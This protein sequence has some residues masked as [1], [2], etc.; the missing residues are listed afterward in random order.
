MRMTVG[1]SLGLTR[2]IPLVFNF[3][4]PVMEGEGDD[5]QVFSFRVSLR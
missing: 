2:P 4:W 1:L 5:V 3:G